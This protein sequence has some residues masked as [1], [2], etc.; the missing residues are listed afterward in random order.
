MISNFQNYSGRMQVK[1]R[2]FNPSML[3]NIYIALIKDINNAFRDKY[4]QLMQ[5]LRTGQIFDCKR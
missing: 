3:S 2:Y 4:S 5:D 1:A